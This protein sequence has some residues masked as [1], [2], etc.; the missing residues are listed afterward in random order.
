MNAGGGRVGGGGGGGDIFKM[1]KNKTRNINFL[2]SKTNTSFYQN[3]KTNKQSFFYV[4]TAAQ[5][6]GST[7]SRGVVRALSNI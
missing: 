3:Q 2:K 6:L 1:T 7:K 5:T 4:T